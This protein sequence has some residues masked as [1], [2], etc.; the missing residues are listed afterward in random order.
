[1]ASTRSTLGLA[2]SCAVL[3]AGVGCNAIFGIGEGHLVAD[4]GA[5]GTGTGGAS[6]GGADAAAGAGGAATGGAGG[7]SGGAATGGSTGTGGAPEGGVPTGVPG[8]VRCGTTTCDLAHQVCCVDSSNGGNPHCSASCDTTVQTSFSCDGKEDCSGQTVCCLPL[9]QSI[10]KCQVDCGAL[11]RVLCGKDGDCAPGKYCAPGTGKLASFGVCTTIPKTKNVWC[12]GAPC[13]VS[14]GNVCCYDPKTK[15]ETCV[16]TGSC[17]SLKVR[18]ACD[19]PEDCPTDTTRDG[20]AAACCPTHNALSLFTGTECSTTGC[21]APIACSTRSDC[22]AGDSCCLDSKNYGSTCS[23]SCF[24]QTACLTD[25]D[26]STG[27]C[28]VATAAVVG[29]RDG[30]GVC[31]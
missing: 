16:A 14:A 8:Q 12:D 5:G 4:S 24:G 1:M 6:S 26:C 3:V 30:M 23:P 19:G 11:G 22:A 20:G 10:A 7:G 9:T 21:V 17:G 28:A 13:D 2:V 18:L 27:T 25:S 15:T 31:Q 29:S